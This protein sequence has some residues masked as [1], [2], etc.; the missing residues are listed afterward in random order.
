MRKLAAIVGTVAVIG[1]GTVGSAEAKPSC[2]WGE[3]TSDAVTSGFP[4][5]P[6]AS[7][8]SGDG[9]AGVDQPRAG[10]GNV[11]EQ[12]NLNATCEAIAAALPG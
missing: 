7:D 10:L 12:G 3:L 9:P 6:H 2:N 5:G 4:Q 11:V 8:P 1:L